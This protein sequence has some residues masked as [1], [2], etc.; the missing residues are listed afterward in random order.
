MALT[1]RVP[2]A[3]RARV[4]AALAAALL[5]LVACAVT[6]AGDVVRVEAQDSEQPIELQTGQ[7]LEIVMQSLPGRNMTLSLG[8]VV[9]PTLAQMGR[10]SFFDDAI[11]GG[12]SGTGSFEVWRFAALQ[13]GTV[14][15][16]MD[17]R[18]PW[19]TTGAPTRSVTYKVVVH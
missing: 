6:P 4:A 19:Q 1:A 5:G 18:L 3:G 15:V 2:G 12:V 17:Y 14:D 8:S 10:P 7:V 16:R 13:P 11:R 9:T